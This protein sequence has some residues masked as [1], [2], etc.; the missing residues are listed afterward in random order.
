MART[1]MMQVFFAT[2]VVL[3]KIQEKI[4]HNLEN[5]GI[6]HRIF[7]N[8][9][10]TMILKSIIDRSHLPNSVLSTVWV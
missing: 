3:D 1:G 4:P 2:M 10:F 9:S 6:G 5:I 7:Y 8:L